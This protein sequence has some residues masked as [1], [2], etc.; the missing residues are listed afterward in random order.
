MASQ[1]PYYGGNHP[2]PLF[3][4]ELDSQPGRPSDTPSHHRPDGTPVFEMSGDVVL[5]EQQPSP[6][7]AKDKPSK[8]PDPDPDP[9][10]ASQPVMANPWAYF[11][12]EPSDGGRRPS[13][14]VYKPYPGNNEPD[15]PE[16]S[17]STRPSDQDVYYPAPLKFAHRPA[18]AVS[19]P[20]FKPYAPPAARDTSDLQPQ[21]LSRPD[22]TNSQSPVVANAYRPYRPYSPQPPAAHS[23]P[24][25]A[26]RPATAS[27][28]Q[29]GLLASPPSV[30]HLFQ[31]T[32][33]PAQF[34][35]PPTPDARLSPI[36]KPTTSLPSSPGSQ[37]QT[38][39]RPQQQHGIPNASPAQPVP[40]SASTYLP[41]PMTPSAQTV[42]V[43]APSPAT[44]ALNVV[45]LTQSQYAAHVTVPSYT[46]APT[47]GITS[48]SPASVAS[49]TTAGVPFSQPQYAAPVQAHVYG[50]NQASTTPGT[51]VTAHSQLQSPVA[52][53]P[54]YNSPQP[55]AQ[56]SYN[57]PQPTYAPANTMPGTF[58]HPSTHQPAPYHQSAHAGPVMQQSYPQQSNTQPYNNTPGPV[59]T[60][61]P[62]SP[63]PP[64]YA[65]LDAGFGVGAQS[66]AA[67]N[68]VMYQSSPIGPYPPQTQFP[69]QPTYAPA[70]SPPLQGHSTYSLQPPALP[71]R[72][73]SSQGFAP[74]S[75]F[76]AGP[77]GYNPASHPRPPQTYFSPPPA[78]PPRPGLGKL[79]GGGGKIFGS[80]SADK[81]LRKTG[82]ALENTLA[83]YMQGQPS[84]Y[85]LGSNGPQGQQGQPVH[86]VPGAYPQGH[87][88]HAPHLAPQFRGN[89]GSGP[90]PHEP[91]AP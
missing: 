70:M 88:F 68:H 28:P 53:S 42:S 29:S 46:Q 48:P 18:N 91:G 15:L 67:N 78:L 3:F 40:S 11:G 76:G 10:D 17:H 54:A 71:P 59:P 82:Q 47:T 45:P 85:R 61:S 81:W 9:S 79:S 32:S 1:T 56:N 24:P 90:P 73:S 69:T 4:A 50:P 55:M 33:P 36:P 58:N 5:A 43:A 83:P 23:V 19:P 84:S 72:P 44:P 7:E 64:P 37:A 34:V 62:Q 25:P 12:P 65:P 57:I 41:S 2:P 30:P 86:Q 27:P 20:A 49:P 51:S 77:A 89:P 31:A 38:L 80:S 52:S 39:P 74:P 63:P 16:I 8:D 60:T 6:G 13:E 87:H 35:A 66:P 26:A 21:P 14:P 22:R 75:G